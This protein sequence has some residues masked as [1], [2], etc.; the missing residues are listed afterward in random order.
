[1]PLKGEF[2]GGYRVRKGKI[3]IIFS[4]GENSEVV[5]EAIIENV[6]FR[7]DIYK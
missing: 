4:I 1:L 2:S 7:G 3:R 6:D 5:I